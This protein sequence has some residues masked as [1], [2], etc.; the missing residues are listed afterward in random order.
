MKKKIKRQE[1]RTKSAPD[2]YRGFRGRLG[3]GTKTLE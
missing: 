1:T 2:G 3:I